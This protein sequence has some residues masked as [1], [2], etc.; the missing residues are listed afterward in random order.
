M[1]A[2]G[3][4]EWFDREYPARPS[5]RP[6]SW[7]GATRPVLH[8]PSGGSD[9]ASGGI[10]LEKAVTRSE[11][12]VNSHWH[13]SMLN[14]TAFVWRRFTRDPCS[15]TAGFGSKYGDE[16]GHQ[17]L[18]MEFLGFNTCC[19]SSTLQIRKMTKH[20]RTCGQFISGRQKGMT[21]PWWIVGKATWMGY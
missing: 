7:P 1:L 16:N 9:R 17:R 5:T 21:R 20:V 11:G 6:T 8:P 19:R 12:R 10:H 2:T 15:R 4:A 3:W 14:L 13:P 18:V